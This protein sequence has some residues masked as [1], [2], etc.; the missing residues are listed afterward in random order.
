MTTLLRLDEITDR[1]EALRSRLTTMQIARLTT[2]RDLVGGDGRFLLRAALEAGEFPEGDSRAQ[3]AFQ[4]FR[5]RVNNAADEAGVDLR[6]ELESRKTPPDRRYG[7]FSG[8]D[9]VEKSI[10]AFT[11]EAA[12]RTG[13]ER[14]VPPEVAELGDSRRT[15]V[16]VSF[17]PTTGAAARGAEKLLEQLR[18]LLGADPE[19]RWEVQ[20]PRS[21][22]LGED[23][24]QTRDRLAS[25]ADVRV[26]LVSPAYLANPEERRRALERPG[27]IVAFAFS[28]LPD[29]PVY[30]GPLQ[31]HDVQRADEPWDGL[32]NT[33]RRSSYVK[34]VVN[35]IRRALSGPSAPVDERLG[36]DDSILTWVNK[37]IRS[38]R[39][40]DSPHLVPANLAETSLQES[41]LGNTDF[42]VSP[43][44]RAVDRLVAWATDSA[45]GAS[46]L[47][48]LLGDVGMGKT[49]TAKLFTKQL[50]KLHKK[51][52]SVP[53]PVHF[54]LRDVRVAALDTSMTLDQILD[55]M[56]DATRPAGVAPERLNADIVRKRFE[57]GNVVVVFDGLDEVLVHLGSHDQQLFTRQLWRAMTDRSAARMLL[58]CRT[59]YFR[60]IRD[61]VAYFTGETRQ[62]LRG[63]DYL[64][65]LMLPFQDEQ[66]REYLAANLGRSEEWV[67]EF[68]QTIAAV[69]DLPDLARRPITL[70]LIAD[71]V[72]FI[73]KAKLQGLALRSID[74]Y[75]EVVERWISRDSGKHTLIPDHK[76]LLMEEIAAAL[77]RSGRNAWS[78]SD[79][80]DWLIDL[81]D[82]RPEL[83][84]HYREH[85]PDLWKADFRTATFLK[86]EGDTFRFAHRSLFE[87]FLAR[88]LFR[89]LSD[90]GLP[91]RGYTSIAIT[92][93]SQETLDFFGQ[94]IDA[95]HGD[96]RSRTLSALQ[97]IGHEYLAEVS[98]LAFAYALHAKNHGYPHQPLAR[99]QLPGAELAGWRI[100]ANE[101]AK[102][103]M[104]H[105]NF[106]GADLRLA[107]FHNVD[108]SHSIFSDADASN[109]EFHGSRLSN[110]LWIGTRAA[111]A[112]LRRC[113]TDDIDFTR[114][115]VYRTKLLDCTSS[116]D[117]DPGLLIA[118]MAETEPPPGARLS[119]L[120]VHTN[121]ARTVAWS[122]DGTRILTGGNGVR[123]WDAATGEII[124]HVTH[125]TD[126][127]NAVAWSPDSTRILT[128]GSKNVRVWSAATGEDL[129]HLTVHARGVQA[130]AWSPNGIRILTG[131]NGINVWNAMTGH[132]VYQRSNHTDPVTAVAWSPHGTRML[133]G[134]NGAHIWNATTGEVV[135]QLADRTDRVHAVAWSPDGTRVLTGGSN[136]ARIWNATTGEPL[137]HL[138]GAANAV[139]WSP[140][141]TRILTGGSNDVRIWNATTGEIVFHRLTVHTHKVHSV[142]WS[143]NGD[144]ILTSG[145]DNT[146]RI[147]DTTTGEQ[148][149]YLTGHTHR[150]HSVAWSPNGDHI[151]TSSDDNTVRIWDTTT[152]ITPRMTSRTDRV[153]AVAWSP[154]GT[155]VL[156]GGSN[157]A[158]IWNAT[159]GDVVHHLTGAANAVA[160]SPD[161]TRILTSSDD[162]TVRTWDTTTGRALHRFTG[163]AD[164]INAMTWSPDG[165]RILTSSDDTTRTWD[166]TT[167]EVVHQLSGHTDRVHAVAWSPDG[168]RVLTGGNGTRIWNATTGEPLHH[169]TGT[170][171]AVAWSPDG[172][173]VL[174]GGNGTRIWNAT[175]G[176]PLHHLTG[177][178]DWINA[179]A[180]SPDGTQILTGSDDSTVRTW[181]ATTGQA[182]GLV[183]AFFPDGELAVYNTLENRVLGCT[184]NAWRWLGWNVVKD[185]RVDLLPA[186]TFGKLP[187]FT[188]P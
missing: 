53:L 86:R 115:K 75:S 56:L 29:G 125:H 149:H 174:T 132:L 82:Q 93:P 127:V 153:K 141:S 186:E 178:T 110:S 41:Q 80:D 164:W 91:A 99:I 20:D 68:L 131:G 147:W 21:V 182:T 187:L 171:N 45:P 42:A 165:T 144:H 66:V 28:S 60:T 11:G 27:R 70:R 26:V 160:W 85:V 67:S 188:D 43:P 64:A 173:R 150:V 107:T 177:H 162:N 175:T 172:T 38:Q 2:I 46:R 69:H 63:S 96:T 49:T 39:R 104:Q 139:A 23:V 117:T 118:P 55:S 74:I 81:L 24:G 40:D 18:N 108:L 17:H 151:L 100:E 158:R 34:H 16:Y 87:Y 116:S 65:L 84:R 37:V 62:G 36:D 123:I 22:G 73:E 130:V 13:G 138:T 121:W 142:A 10:V 135:H 113:D 176:E 97:E 105:A 33:S 163:H 7:W 8:G 124:H 157:E 88:Y 102:L 109:T 9:L 168:T 3:D 140:D 170:T 185:G 30:L 166:A 137:H 89:T 44:L 14:P 12:E 79:V 51:D 152:G 32:V 76:R 92:V 161:S 90:A 134:G 83:R 128:G 103:P 169:L 156:T 6:L 148:L 183:F 181:D 15:R 180:W 48:A 50:L 54:D 5:R 120:I 25:E 47:C 4:D 184:G 111:G 126:P 72:E 1:I 167:G 119:H 61:E 78:P 112:V 31:R 146:V 98:E 155:R 145:N 106:T 59:Q 101:N 114:T 136:E 57:K 154:D 179:V 143:P 94:S 77:W 19:R 159:T 71:Q 129:H 52:P 122:P 95:A 133:T 58:T 35:E